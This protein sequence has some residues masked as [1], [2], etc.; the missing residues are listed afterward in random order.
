MNR[1]L[2]KIPMPIVGLMLSFASLGNL[3]EPYGKVYKTILG[4]L[5]A[6]LFILTTIKF[7]CGFSGLKKE[8]STPIGASIFPNYTMSIMLL[9]TY[10][11]PYNQEVAYGIWIA[12]I[13]LHI[14]LIIYFTRRFVLH[15]NIMEVF[16]SWFIVYVGIAVAAVTGKA[17]NQTIGQIA[18]CF[19][20]LSYLILIP[21]VVKRVLFVK[22]IPEPALPTLI[23][24]SA[25]GSLCLAGYINS[26]KTKHM[27]LL[28]FLLI[29]SQVIYLVAVI[30]LIPL[31]KL[32]FYPSY[33]GFTFPLVISAIALKSSNAYLISQGH[34]FGF[35]SVLVKTEEIIATLIVFY[36]F[37]RYL[38]HIVR[39][40]LRE[41]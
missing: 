3:L 33:S 2:N 32:K 8:L 19:A 9:A 1:F 17:F 24:F 15:F 34:T 31:L 11:K 23:I 30:K 14:I 21:I 25:P 6:S 7:L 10:I 29:L 22:N 16:P 36:V 4:V 37:I 26:F 39:L 27:L 18:F 20:F 40:T 41:S 28:V 5:S 35:L 13:L 38:N 12:S